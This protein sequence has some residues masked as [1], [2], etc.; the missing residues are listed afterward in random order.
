MVVPLADGTVTISTGKDGRVSVAIAMN[1]GA[2]PVSQSPATNQSSDK[3]DTANSARW[4][5]HPI[6]KTKAE[7]EAAGQREAEE[8]N[9][10]ILTFLGMPVFESRYM[11]YAYEKNGGYTY[12]AGQ[13]LG[14]VV[15]LP[16][17]LKAPSTEAIN[18]AKS[19]ASES[20]V[21]E[22]LAGGGRPIAGAGTSTVLKDVPRLVNQYGGEESAWAK[23][24]SS[25]YKAADNFIV[26]THAY[27]NTLTGEIVELKS[28]LGN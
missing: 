12:W 20:Q 24:S 14:G 26:E 2:A 10:D 4:G 6:F 13:P 19:I 18:L 22:I 25:V 8:K 16:G 28:K 11:S 21:A 1:N 3:G 9:K 27:L 23:I 15:P 7:A 17:S 5:D